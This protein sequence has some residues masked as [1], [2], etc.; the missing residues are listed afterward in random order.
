MA[1]LTQSY[2]HGASDVPLIGETIG[3]LF[4]RGGRRAGASATALIV[5][6]PGRALDLCANC[7]RRVDALRRRA[8]GARA[9][10]GRPRRHLVAEQRRM[11]GDAVRHRQGR[12]DPGQH[13][14]GLSPDR[15][16]IRAQQGRLQGAGHRRR[17]SRPATMSACCASWRPSSTRSAPG[18]LRA[19]RLPALQHADPDRRGE[20][21][22]FLRFDDVLG[23]GRRRGSAPRSTELRADAAVRRCHQHPVHQ[24]HHRRA[25]GRDAHPS[26]HPQQRLLRRRGDAAHRPATAS[27][28]RCRS[29]TASAWCW[30]TSPAS[31]TARP[32]SIPARASIRCATLEAVAGG[33]LHR[34]LRR[35]DHVHRRAR[36]SASSR[37]S[38]CRSLRTG[39][40][41]GS[42]CP[43]EVMKR[44]R[45]RDAHERGDH[46]LRHDRDQPGQLPDA[47][48]TIRSSGASPRSAASIRMSR[49]RSSMPRAASCRRARRASSA[50]A[51]IR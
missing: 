51:A 17:A 41:A 1:K 10:A 26:Q 48:S 13:Q 18:Q 30:A 6:A 11:G 34:A 33:A 9:R 40:M 47:P 23:A 2:V 50:R 44:V 28:S 21:P 49:S 7:R 39:I 8:A 42:P 5:R 15:A 20:A 14:P 19:Q 43:I 31:R 27:A 38:I 12:P 24:R 45:Q 32:W 46:R 35:A 25:Q 16:R 4:R 36:P 3:A 29:I 22:G 37:A